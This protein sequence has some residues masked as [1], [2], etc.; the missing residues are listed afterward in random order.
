MMLT[1]KNNDNFDNIY[2]CTTRSFN[3]NDKT[4]LD[5]FQNDIYKLMNI[6]NPIVH[7]PAYYK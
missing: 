3:T 1:N 5:Q 7:N 6:C 2:P 4:S